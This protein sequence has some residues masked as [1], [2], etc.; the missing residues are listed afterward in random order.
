M[1]DPG[2]RLRSVVLDCPDPEALAR[3]YADL[4][5]VAQEQ[6][7]LDPEWSEVRLAE[8][9]VKLA[10]QRAEGHVRPVWPDGT[11]QQVHLDLTVTDLAGSSTRAVGLGAEVLGAPVDEDGCTFQVHADPAGHPFCLCREH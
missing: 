1:A 2:L 7:T 6:V 11:P 3:F 4:F 9:V 10:F 5:A 8:P